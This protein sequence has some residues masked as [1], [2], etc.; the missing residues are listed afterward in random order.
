[1]ANHIIPEPG[2]AASV[3][4]NGIIYA[5]LDNGAIYKFIYNDGTPL[6]ELIESEPSSYTS[7]QLRHIIVFEQIYDKVGYNIKF[8]GRHTTL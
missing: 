4:F 1:V 8:N 6:W 5:R 3:K 7:D 2:I